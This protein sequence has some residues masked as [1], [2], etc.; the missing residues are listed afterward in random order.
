MYA[1]VLLVERR[2]LLLFFA[3]YCWVF[4]TVV[5]TCPLLAERARLDSS[6]NVYIVVVHG[7]GCKEMKERRIVEVED[8]PSPPHYSGTTFCGGISGSLGARVL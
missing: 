1:T 4:L 5:V 2:F 8:N 3:C 6:K 7:R